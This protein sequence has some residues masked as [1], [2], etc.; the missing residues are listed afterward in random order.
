M[1]TILTP[2]PLTGGYRSYH[3]SGIP[4]TPMFHRPGWPTV[5]HIP[6]TWM[7][8]GQ[9]DLLNFPG[10]ATYLSKSDAFTNVFKTSQWSSIVVKIPTYSFEIHKIHYSYTDQIT[11]KISKIPCSVPAPNPGRNLTIG[12]SFLQAIEGTMFQS[13]PSVSRERYRSASRLPMHV[14]PLRT[15]RKHVYTASSR[16]ESGVDECTQGG[17]C[18]LTLIIPWLNPSS[19]VGSIPATRIFRRDYSSKDRDPCDGKTV[20]KRIE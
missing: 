9:V 14:G 7:T 5:A 20:W 3:G 19:A 18:S 1:L 8:H 2:Q 17:T 4:G 12:Q 10:L 11:A 13:Y 15:S 16:R 6:K